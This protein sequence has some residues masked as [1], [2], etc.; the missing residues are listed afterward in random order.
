MPQAL[1]TTWI[2]KNNEPI[3][4]PKKNGLTLSRE[5]KD[6]WMFD[7][8]DTIKKKKMLVMNFIIHSYLAN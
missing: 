3:N 7:A 4:H 1:R 8:K 2:G 6:I 5:K